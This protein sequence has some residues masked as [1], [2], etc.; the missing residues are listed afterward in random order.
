MLTFAVVP[1][2]R[3]YRNR[4]SQYLPLDAISNQTSSLRYRI[5]N[6][7]AS[8]TLPS[9]WSRERHVAFAGGELPDADLGDGEELEDVDEVMSRV[10][11]RLASSGRPDNDRRLSREYVPYIIIHPWLI[12]QADNSEV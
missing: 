9:A 4:Y 5:T 12:P 6:R 2:W 8:L 10:L 11:G 1:V 3:R 7:L